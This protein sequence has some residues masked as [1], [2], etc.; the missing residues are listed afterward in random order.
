MT[1]QNGAHLLLRDRKFE[2]TEPVIV[3]ICTITYNHASFLG[4]CI[5]AF[6]DQRC[7]FKV[8]IIIYDDASTDGTTDIVRDYAERYPSIIKPIFGKK[9]VFSLGVNPY[10]AFVFPAA[11]GEFLAICDGDDYWTEPEKLSKQVAAL[12]SD[13]SISIVY[14]SIFG[15][16]G[17]GE[18]V[19]FSVT[20]ERDLSRMEL[21][22]LP[23]INTVTSCF[24]NPFIKSP[25]DF[26]R[27]SPIGDQTI[28]AI[29]GGMGRG[30]FMDD[31][32][33]S[34]YRIHDAGIF[35]KITQ[36]RKYYMTSITRLCIAAFHN[37]NGNIDAE[38]LLLSASV[39]ELTSR[40]GF[41]RIVYLALRNTVAR[42]VN[43]FRSRI[44]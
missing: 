25:P 41:S 34:G 35:S 33:P 20:K 17:G 40:L 4:Q 36:S 37:Q 18:K 31:L 19:P 23:A 5:D 24:R 2:A 9:N 42:G 16:V 27:Y 29:L 7:D 30:H 8:E 43:S 32:K 28:W 12:R 21:Q 26:L 3:S 38:S 14:G 6:L 15:D 22:A 10:Y 13:P 44:F 1:K 11:R 39:S